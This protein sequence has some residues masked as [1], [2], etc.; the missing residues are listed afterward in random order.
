[1]TTMAALGPH[2]VFIASAYAV[3]LLVVAGLIAWVVADHRMQRRRLRDLEARGI[4]R[5]SAR[6]G[7]A[8]S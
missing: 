2:A 8:A 7:A 4:I 5:R 1:M 6:D 3:A